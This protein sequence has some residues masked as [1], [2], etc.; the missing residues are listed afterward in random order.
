MTTDT[1]DRPLTLAEVMESVEH[2]RRRVASG[3]AQLHQAMARLSLPMTEVLLAHLDGDTMAP[4]ADTHDRLPAER[5]SKTRRFRLPV[6]GSAEV[7]TFYATAGFY[8]DGRLGEVF[9][10]PDG[11]LDDMTRGLLDA[12]CLTLSMALQHGVQ[13][14]KLLRKLRGQ[15][16]GP[17]GWTGE[18]GPGAILRA[19][20]VVDYVAQWLGSLLEG[21][22]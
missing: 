12:W 6:P 10:T 3:Q 2:M 7:A 18:E 14:K 1:H 11:H 17:G 4:P 15:S 21:Q 13:P 9:V 20:S 22:G 8:Q 19:S 16:F 5:G